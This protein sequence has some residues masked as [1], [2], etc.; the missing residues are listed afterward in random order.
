MKET[1][2]KIN[3][4]Y[5]ELK[6]KVTNYVEEHQG[7]Q[8]YIETQFS[9]GGDCIYAIVYDFDL[10]QITEQYVYGVRVYNG[11][12]EVAL[13]PSES[14]PEWSKEDF[15][16][17]QWISVAEGSSEIYFRPTIDSIAENIHEYV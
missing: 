2:M 17:T 1:R 9:L 6:E 8:G 14:L 13:E 16:E 3:D 10:A 4:L 5:K 15:E 11:N 12:L 7:E